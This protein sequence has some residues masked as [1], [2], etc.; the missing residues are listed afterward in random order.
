MTR[1]C[2]FPCSSASFSLCCLHIWAYLYG[3]LYVEMYGEPDGGWSDLRS[4]LEKEKEVQRQGNRRTGKSSSDVR[5]TE[6]SCL[7]KE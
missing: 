1:M 2:V 7:H 5:K 3:C 6:S 4:L